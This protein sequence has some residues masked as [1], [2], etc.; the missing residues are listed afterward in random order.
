MKKL[1]L[2]TFTALFILNGC[3][4]KHLLTESTTHERNDSTTTVIIRDTVINWLPQK[5]EVK[6]NQKSKLS[7]D[8]SFSFAWID[9]AGLLNHSIENF[10]KIPSKIKEVST[11]VYKY[12]Y[13][14]INK[15]LEITKKVK[16]EVRKYRWVSY[17]DFII[18]GLLIIFIV[19][20]RLSR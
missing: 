2:I 4:P 11:K 7:T 10:P 12:K 1:I 3:K 8:F 15:T 14:K 9:S 19:E 5:Q 18:L 20:K 16:V 13:I 17:F 6:T